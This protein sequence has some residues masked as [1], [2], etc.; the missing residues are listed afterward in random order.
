MECGSLTEQQ[1]RIS[2]YRFHSSC[3]TRWSRDG[4]LNVHHNTGNDGNGPALRSVVNRD[5]DR[6]ICGSK[7]WHAEIRVEDNA[8]VMGIKKGW[9]IVGDALNAAPSLLCSRLF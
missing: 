4:N 6:L 8:G 1:A 5:V 9:A 7:E 2:A 3:Y